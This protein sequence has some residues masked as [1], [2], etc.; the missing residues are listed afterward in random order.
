VENIVVLEWNDE[1]TLEII[2]QRADEIAAVI[3]EPVQSRSPEIQPVDFLRK[4]RK[5]TKDNG[6]AMIMDE[7]VTGFRVAPGGAQEYWGIEADIATFGKVI[8]GGLSLGVV[9]GKKEYMDTLDG[10]AWQYGDDSVPEVGVT[11]FAGTFVRHPIMV[12]VGIA[13]LEYLKKQGPGLQKGLNE[14]TNAWVKRMNDLFAAEEAP[15]R[16]HNF[17]SVLKID[18]DKSVPFSELLFILLRMKGIHTWDGRPNFLTL[19]HTDADL[20]RVYQAFQEAIAELQDGGFYPK[21]AK[22]LKADTPPVP[23]ARLGRNPAGQPAWFV[24]DPAP[25]GQYIELK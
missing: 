20:D 8:G 21:P 13:V 10:G 14:K 16:I 17:C 18:A 4:L 7:V 1:A 24:P 22:Q 5:V 23:G 12:A 6:I 19:A 9:A 2:R 3:A 25:P 15:V 11:Y